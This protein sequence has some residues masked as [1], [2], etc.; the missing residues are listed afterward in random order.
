MINR[1]KPKSEFARNVLTLMTGTT[2]AQAIPVAVTPIL[3]R[4]YTPEDFGLLTLFI[5]VTMI[6]ASMV[7]GRYELAI[8]LPDN[9]DEAIN[10]AALGFLIATVFSFILFVAAVIFNTQIS[11]LLNSQK[12]GP[13]LYIAPFAVW[14]IGFFNVLN[15]LN[16]RKKLF[17][18][19][20]KVKI[21][22]SVAMTVVQLGVGLVKTGASGLIMG[23]IVSHVAANYKLM[24]AVIH[25]FDFSIISTSEVCRLSKRYIDFPKY[26]TVASLANKLSFNLLYILVSTIYGLSI[27]GFYSVSQRV[28]ALPAT[29]IGTAIGQVYF[30]QA[31][32]EK[33][34]TGRSIVVFNATLKKL[35]ILAIPSFGIL[36]FF[37][38]DLFVIFFGENWAESGEYAEILVP[39][40]AMQ[41]VSSSLSQ[42]TTVFEKMK[43]SLVI[44]SLILIV[45]LLLCLLLREDKIQT[46]LTYLSCS[47]SALY[48][49]FLLYYRF[50]AKGAV[51]NVE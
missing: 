40:F 43:A 5:A 41:F 1:L 39:F 51:D 4:I 12:I 37:V 9:D 18:N 11:G 25:S 35:L 48:F 32:L 2:V 21:Y 17:G 16:T 10:I 46:L 14:M 38:K 6:P 30:Q 45:V 19:L 24:K 7:N 29:L 36:Y 47:L 50:L 23:Q 3:T 22:K 8:M 49:C 15:Y 42:T 13:W 34:R 31:S 28:L 33:Q 26:S 27:L 44:N 20:A